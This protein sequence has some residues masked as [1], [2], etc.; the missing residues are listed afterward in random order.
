MQSAINPIEKRIVRNFKQFYD[1][2]LYVFLLYSNKQKQIQEDN[3]SLGPLSSTTNLSLAELRGRLAALNENTSTP[4]VVG[5]ER[6]MI[7]LN[8][9]S[10]AICGS[11]DEESSENEEEKVVQIQEEVCVN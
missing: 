5:E 9:L 3:I 11:V 7:L 4:G 8:R 2:S 10:A 6:R 1:F